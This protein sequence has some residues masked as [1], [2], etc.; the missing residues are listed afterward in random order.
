MCIYVCVSLF[1][2]V[3]HHNNSNMQ[4]HI[5]INIVVVIFRSHAI[6]LELMRA[7][8]VSNSTHSLA[9]LLLQKISKTLLVHRPTVDSAHAY[10][11]HLLPYYM[12]VYVIYMQVV[13]ECVHIVIL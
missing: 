7:S 11:V 6:E 3:P 9:T 1:V 10:C 5:I 12:N 8:T 4:Q 2:H 13:E